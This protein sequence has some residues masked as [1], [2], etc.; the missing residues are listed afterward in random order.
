MIKLHTSYIGAVGLVAFPST[1]LHA[2]TLV[3]T[4]KTMHKRKMYSKMTLYIEACESGSMFKGLLPDDI[5]IYATTASNATTSSYACYYDDYLNTYLG[6]VYSV[7]WLEDSDKENLN[8]ET[9][10]QQYKIVRRE[11]NTSQVCQFGDLTIAKKMKVA[12][13]QGSSKRPLQ[14]NNFNMAHHVH[15]T[16]SLLLR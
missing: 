12:D 1:V 11:T 5:N 16:Q 10:E 13:F 3:K 2:T 14:G 7:K 8:R 15:R 9:L 4:L 6:D